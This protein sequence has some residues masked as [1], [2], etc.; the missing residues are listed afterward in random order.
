MLRRTNTRFSTA[1]IIVK[2]SIFVPTQ[3]EKNERGISLS[4]SLRGTLLSSVAV[5]SSWYDSRMET[6]ET[7][8]V[9]VSSGTGSGPRSVTVNSVIILTLCVCKR[10]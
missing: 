7:Q 1:C 8:K 10:Y 6:Q 3:V 2:Y 5:N 9:S 4:K